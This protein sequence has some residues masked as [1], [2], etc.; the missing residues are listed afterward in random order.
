[1]NSAETEQ[2]WATQRREAAKERARMLEARKEAES[3]KAAKIVAAF[4]QVAANE[5]LESFPLRAKGYGGGSAKTALRGWY[6]RTD[7]T[8]ALDT[9]G[10]F[11]ILTMS[12]SRREKLFGAAPLPKPVPLTI[13]EGGRDGDI[14]PLRF[15]LERLLPG[16]EARTTLPLV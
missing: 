4:L 2:D 10:K 16:W 1:M 9:Q 15:A 12:L 14:V 11:Y 7:E 5:G 3:A 13:G 6:L 8:V